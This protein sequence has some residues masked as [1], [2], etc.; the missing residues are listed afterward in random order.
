MTANP[1]CIPVRGKPT[2]G[3]QSWNLLERLF[4]LFR[5][6]ILDKQP[7]AACNIEV[8]PVPCG[9]LTVLHIEPLFRPKIKEPQPGV[10]TDKLPLGCNPKASVPVRGCRHHGL[11]RK[12]VL[13]V[14][15]RV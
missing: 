11:H 10:E 2:D 5:R 13:A 4:L 12:P 15:M 9:H 3:S 6:K 8:A 7:S 14:Q 1:E